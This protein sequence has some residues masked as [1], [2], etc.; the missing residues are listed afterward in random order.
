MTLVLSVI[1]LLYKLQHVKEFY[2]YAMIVP[3]SSRERYHELLRE[4][5]QEQYALQIAR[6]NGHDWMAQLLLHLSA[7]L[8]NSGNRLQAYLEMPPRLSQR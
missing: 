5:A 1:D 3:E 2:M 4:C 8:I 6:V 7:W